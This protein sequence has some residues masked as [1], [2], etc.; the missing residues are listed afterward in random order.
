MPRPRRQCK[1]NGVMNR[2]AVAVLLLTL[3]GVASC[4]VE[5]DPLADLPAALQRTIAA[6]DEAS[7]HRLLVAMRQRRPLRDED[8]ARLALALKSEVNSSLAWPAAYCPSA[9]AILAGASEPLSWIRKGYDPPSVGWLAAPCVVASSEPYLPPDPTLLAGLRRLLGGAGDR[10]PLMAARLLTQLRREEREEVA[11]DLI[12]ALTHPSDHVSAQC[13]TILHDLGVLVVPRLA[14]KISSASERKATQIAQTLGL[15]GTVAA[16]ARGGL[17]ALLAHESWM[18][19]SSAA[20]ALLGFDREHGRARDVLLSE[21]SARGAGRAPTAS[22]AIAGRL[23]L[24]G[25]LPRLRKMALRR[26]LSGNTRWHVMKTISCLE[27]VKRVRGD[28]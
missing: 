26:D 10:G 23:E 8:L 7:Y 9:T 12:E 25:V 15:M 13:K 4:G 20:V 18:A 21:L 11:D 22:F 3:L 1:M 27:S 16:P 14:A 5:P 17:E 6:R 28:K 19:R 2:V 24:V